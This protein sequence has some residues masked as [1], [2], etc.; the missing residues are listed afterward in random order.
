V[1]EQTLMRT[2]GLACSLELPRTDYPEEAVVWVT[3]VLM[4]GWLDKFP[5]LKAAVL[6]SNA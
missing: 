5:K 1:A 4:P 3:T 2:A 6:E